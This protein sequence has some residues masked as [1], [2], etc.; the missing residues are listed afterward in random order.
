M[1]DAPV[2]DPDLSNRDRL[3]YTV[4][5]FLAF[6]IFVGVP[7]T[8]AATVV[9]NQFGLKGLNRLAVLLAAL[10]LTARVLR[11]YTGPF[12][13]HPRDQA[14]RDAAAAEAE[15]D[16]EEGTEGGSEGATESDTSADAESGDPASGEDEDAAGADDDA[17]VA[18][19][20]ADDDADVA[21]ADVDDAV[22][23]TTED[24][25]SVASDDEE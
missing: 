8:V 3:K 7:V 5:R 19:A 11:P 15:P 2:H 16:G 6:I 10:W 24:A 12:F 22:D 21:P 4:P 25:D 18:P 23:A 9:V 1:S 13:R 17:D 14:A 20:D